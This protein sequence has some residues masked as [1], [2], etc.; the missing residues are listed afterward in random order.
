MQSTP[1]PLAAPKPTAMCPTIRRQ[2][3]RLPIELVHVATRLR[4][5]AGSAFCGFTDQPANSK[6]PEVLRAASLVYLGESRCAQ[7]D[8]AA[9]SG[10]S[11]ATKWDPPRRRKMQN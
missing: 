10:N 8:G 7:R 3:C 1:L 9:K 4:F 5:V 11:V 6:M 2:R